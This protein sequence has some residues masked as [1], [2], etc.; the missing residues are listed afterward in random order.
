MLPP[1][2][3]ASF[4]KS[5]STYNT[6]TGGTLRPACTGRIVALIPAYNEERFIG[7]VVIK[8]RRYVDDVI[9]VD[10]R[11]HRRN[12]LVAQS[13]AQ[14]ETSQS[15]YSCASCGRRSKTMG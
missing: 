11:S 2:I 9:V 13:H 15:L 8:T 5:A 1:E 7:S 6:F 4:G 14:R 3:D 12:R 10:G